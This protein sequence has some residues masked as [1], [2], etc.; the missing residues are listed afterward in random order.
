VDDVA[1]LDG[2]FHQDPRAKC[3]HF[4][5]DLVCVQLQYGVAGVDRL[6]LLL[7]PARYGRFNNGLPEGRNFQSDH[8]EYL[9]V[10]P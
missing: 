3:R 5:G 4:D 8:F 10:C 7:Y 1:F 6:A 2:L 9:D